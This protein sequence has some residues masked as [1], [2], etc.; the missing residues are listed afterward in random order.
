M[1]GIR[2]VAMRMRSRMKTMIID[3]T[4]AAPGPLLPYSANAQL[5]SR[6]TPC[7]VKLTLRSR[8]LCNP[9]HYPSS[10][11]SHCV[12]HNSMPTLFHSL[13]LNPQL[14]PN[15]T[16][17]AASRTIGLQLTARI[18][19]PC[20]DVHHTAHSPRQSSTPHSP[21]SSMLSSTLSSIFSS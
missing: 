7:N 3:N 18:T 13:K 8:L 19:R 12:H 16:H 11:T 1:M 20:C 4:M 15:A 2:V 21:Y 5:T 14:T 17:H 10:P 6:V 9:C